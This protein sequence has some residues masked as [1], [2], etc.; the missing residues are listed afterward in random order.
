MA[1]PSALE[2]LLVYG[3]LKRGHANH[4]HLAGA[5][6]VQ[7]ATLERLVLHDLGP[8]PMAVPGDGQVNG[9]LYRLSA[10]HWPALDYLEGVPRLYSR[11]RWRS[12]EG[13]W[14]WVYLGSLRQVRHARQLKDGV[15]SGVSRPGRQDE[16]LDA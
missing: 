9:E 10:E 7:E 4:Q 11:W 3:T 1:D 8:F 15:W 16:R 13:H 12:S 14:L 5:H 2:L 6:F